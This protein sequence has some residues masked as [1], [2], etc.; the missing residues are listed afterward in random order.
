MFRILVD[1]LMPRYFTLVLPFVFALL[2]TSACSHYRLGIGVERDY[3]SIFIPPI[4]T[5]AQ[6][7]QAA[8][9][10]TTQ[11][12]EAFIRDG[13]LRVVNTADEADAVLSVEVGKLTRNGLTSLPTDSGLSR[14]MGLTLDVTAT[15]RDP[16]GKKTWFAHRAISIERQIFTDDGTMNP[17]AATTYLKPVQQ[18]QAEYQIVPQLAE[19]LADRLKGTVLETW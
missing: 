15:L 9:I 18:T 4:Q 11:I 7:P 16:K 17:A 2:F 14:K 12:R 8:A 6:L 19:V 3:E 10:F 5:N 13:S 1:V